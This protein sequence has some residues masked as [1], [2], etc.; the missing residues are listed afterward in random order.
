MMV[1]SA[2]TRSIDRVDRL[3]SGGT[4]VIDYKSGKVS[5][6]KRVDESLRAGSPRLP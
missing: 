6:Q 4:E 3:S 5:S 1:Q 2:L